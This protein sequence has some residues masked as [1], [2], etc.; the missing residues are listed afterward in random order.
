MTPV[1]VLIDKP[2][3]K[4]GE[5]EYVGVAEKADGVIVLVDVIAALILA[6]LV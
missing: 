5:M 3:G 4:L 2:V 6:T 1:E